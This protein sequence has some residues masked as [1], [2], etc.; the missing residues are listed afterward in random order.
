[1]T[2]FKNYLKGANNFPVE[3]TFQNTIAVLAFQSYR[4]A[5]NPQAAHELTAYSLAATIESLRRAG[6][7]RCVV[8]VLVPQDIPMV[9]DAFRHLADQVDPKRRPANGITKIGHL[10]VGYA[11]SS[12]AYIKTKHVV[13]NMPR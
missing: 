9:E 5:I 2:K 10:E 1:M 4:S 8:A 12:H 7:G 6:F 13:K 3:N 11:Y